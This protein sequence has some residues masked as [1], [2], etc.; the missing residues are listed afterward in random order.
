MIVENTKEN[1]AKCIC[2]NCPSFNECMKGVAQAL[3]C[4]REK[5]SCDFD[6]KGCVCSGCPLTSE[7]DL[8]SDYFCVSGVA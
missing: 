6:K 3:F 7:N 2:G 4:A 8:S 5:S 1:L